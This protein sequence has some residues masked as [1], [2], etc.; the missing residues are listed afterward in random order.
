MP[1]KT[2]QEQIGKKDS[3][4]GN[5]NGKIDSTF[6]PHLPVDNGFGEL[7]PHHYSNPPGKPTGFF[8]GGAD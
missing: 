5:G 3:N 1:Q 7:V 2:P 8:P 6:V 4:N